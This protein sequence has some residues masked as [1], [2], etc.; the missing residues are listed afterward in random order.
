M[1]NIT[2]YTIN[3]VTRYSIE[4][5]PSFKVEASS[6]AELLRFLSEYGGENGA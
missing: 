5:S 1:S 4:L 3:G 2:Y 6:L